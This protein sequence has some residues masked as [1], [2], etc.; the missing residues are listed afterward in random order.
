M[1]GNLHSKWEIHFTIFYDATNVLCKV[2][3]PTSPKVLEHLYHIALT[4][5]EYKNVPEFSNILYPIK[6]KFR[7]YWKELPMLFPLTYV[8][9][10]D[11]I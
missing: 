7:K 3:Y 9:D 5:N 4:F 10:L 11:I 6:T 1:I 8:M 2:C